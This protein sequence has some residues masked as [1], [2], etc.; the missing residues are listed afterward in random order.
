M[1]KVIFSL[2]VFQASAAVGDHQQNIFP[3]DFIEKKLGIKTIL[4]GDIVSEALG[5]P[6]LRSATTRYGTTV[7]DLS[8]LPY[9]SPILDSG[10][11]PWTSWW[12]PKIDRDFTRPRDVFRAP[13]LEK[14]DLYAQSL[15]TPRSALAFEISRETPSATW[16]GLCD[17]WA[18]ASI[19]VPEP[20]NGFRVPVRRP[21]RLTDEDVAFSVF[22]IKGLV[23]KMYEAV[24]EEHF[25]YYGEKF[26]GTS[27]GWIYPD[28]FPS[29]FHRLID[30][31]LGEM[32]QPFLM[33]HDPGPE[34]WTVPV[35][36]ANYRIEA[37]EGVAN[38]VKVKLWVFTAGPAESNEKNY[39][40]TKQVIREY[41]YNLYGDLDRSGRILTVTRGQW[42]GDS[43]I[44]HPDY[45]FAPKSHSVPR[46]SYNQNLSPSVIDDLLSRSLE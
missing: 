27:N 23:L 8:R 11:R 33:D 12:Y 34:V 16:E 28:L 44:G 4:S 5:N 17:A 18:I 43:V 22:D 35:F 39:V 30:H 37:L 20:K 41:T 36:K 15:S 13:I 14:Y 31:Y 21:G 1:W 29:E 3:M 10:R 45:L 46:K 40:G 38:A 24:E 42:T 7:I 26:T 32:Q 25:D 19:L 9:A 6:R 2:L